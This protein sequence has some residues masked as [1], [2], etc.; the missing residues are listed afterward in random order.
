MQ[1]RIT[2]WSTTGPALQRLAVLARLASR[3]RWV[4]NPLWDLKAW[5]HWGCEAHSER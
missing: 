3:K 2:P 4:L 1:P 5:V